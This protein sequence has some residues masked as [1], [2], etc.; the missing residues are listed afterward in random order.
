MG[1][2]LRP[3]RDPT[4]RCQAEASALTWAEGADDQGQSLD[5]KSINIYKKAVGAGDD[6]GEGNNKRRENVTDADQEKAAMQIQNACKMHGKKKQKKATNPNRDQ[7][8]QTGKL[9]E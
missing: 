9:A 8:E 4:G 7:S 6:T 3:T 2:V 5:K 1:G